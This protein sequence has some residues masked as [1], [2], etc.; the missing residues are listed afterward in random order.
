MNKQKLN[1]FIVLIKTNLQWEIINENE[2]C[3]NL[4]TFIQSTC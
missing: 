2:Y 1:D 4:I 3:S